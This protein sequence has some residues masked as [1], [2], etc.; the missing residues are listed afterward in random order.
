MVITASGPD[1]GRRRLLDTRL[2]RTTVF[3]ISPPVTIC[4]T[5]PYSASLA[6]ACCAGEF[7]D[8]ATAVVTVV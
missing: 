4:M 1:M 8:H 2:C 6:I 3:V 7:E 5:D